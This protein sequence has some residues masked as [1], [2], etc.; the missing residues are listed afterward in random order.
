MFGV[1]TSLWVGRS[2]AARTSGA[3]RRRSEALPVDRT[4]G[5]CRSHETLKYCT[6]FR[7][8]ANRLAFRAVFCTFISILVFTNILQVRT[9]NETHL[10]AFLQRLAI[11]TCRHHLPTFSRLCPLKRSKVGTKTT[12]GF[13][14]DRDITN[15]AHAVSMAQ[16]TTF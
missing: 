2:G 16:F 7:V 3:P 5:R 15:F 8:T 10:S 4:I 12:S 13:S 6:I 9:E 14:F 1:G 11:L